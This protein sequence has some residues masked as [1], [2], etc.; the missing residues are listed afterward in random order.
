M[1]AEA[2]EPGPSHW[3]RGTSFK[4]GGVGLGEGSAAEVLEEGPDS[5][6]IMPTGWTAGRPRG[7]RED[8]GSDQEGPT[9]LRDLPFPMM[10]GAD[11]VR[12]GNTNVVRVD[13]TG[14]DATHAVVRAGRGNL[15][16]TG[17]AAPRLAMV[18]ITARLDC[19]A[20]QRAGRQEADQE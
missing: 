6:G 14:T 13:G 20:D 18:A 11:Q 7:G 9:R 5:R 4:E 17:V 8:G 3:G 12:F 15:G 10:E 1:I 2:R 16:L 19:P